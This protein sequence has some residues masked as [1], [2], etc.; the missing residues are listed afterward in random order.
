MERI[1]YGRPGETV[2]ATA[3]SD[4]GEELT[5]SS[6]FLGLQDPKF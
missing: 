1:G 2:C 4:G 6:S 3:V 5:T